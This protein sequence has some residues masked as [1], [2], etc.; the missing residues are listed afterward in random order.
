MI[1]EFI[2]GLGFVSAWSTATYERFS[3]YDTDMPKFLTP[4]PLSPPDELEET[5]NNIDTGEGPQPFWGFV[6]FPLDQLMYTNDNISFSDVSLILNTWGSSNVMFASMMDMVNSWEASGKVQAMARQMY[7]YATS[8]NQVTWLL[9]NGDQFL[10]ETSFDPFVAGSSLSHVDHD[11]YNDSSDYLMIYNARRGVSLQEMSVKYDNYTLGP[12]LLRALA[13]IGYNVTAFNDQVT[14]VSAVTQPTLEFWE[15][16]IP[17][18]GTAH[19]PSPSIS[20]HTDGPA[21]IPTSSSSSS[22]SSTASSSDSSACSS[23]SSAVTISMLL[24]VAALFIFFL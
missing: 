8:S 7:S 5:S 24:L 20:T 15:P 3:R 16:A 23:P 12:L 4:V 22:S 10:S 19:N 13:N 18:V 21:H 9:D 6:D 17:M 11:T 14:M 1:H 2:H